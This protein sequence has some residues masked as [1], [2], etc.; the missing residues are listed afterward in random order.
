M[1]IAWVSGG[2][3]ADANAH[4]PTN[5]H[6]FLDKLNPDIY[7]HTYHNEPFGAIETAINI[8]KLITESPDVKAFHVPDN[9]LN[10]K[11]PETNIQNCFFMWRKRQLAFKMINI[12]Q[13]DYVVCGRLDV[14][15]KNEFD[16][17]WLTHIDDSNILVPAGGDYR[18]G[19]NDI[20]AIGNPKTMKIY[21]NLIDH[22]YEYCE[23]GC[24]FHPEQLLKY[25]LTK[26]NIQAHRFQMAILVRGIPYNG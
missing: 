24:K 6:N 1:K 22:I 26:Y 17:K 15:Y 14:E 25:H 19:L 16:T 10:H 8:K 9:I 18:G 11:E 21:T 23:Q 12:D 5:K 4:L 20:I 13:Y 7:I 2:K 3:L